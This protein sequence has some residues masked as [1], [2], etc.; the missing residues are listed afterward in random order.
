MK[1]WKIKNM[2]NYGKKILNEKKWERKIEKNITDRK[3][4]KINF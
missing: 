1:N 2:K 4:K 3:N